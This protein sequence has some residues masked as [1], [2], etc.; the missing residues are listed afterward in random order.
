[1]Y[2]SFAFYQK[3][4]CSF[5]VHFLLLNEKD[6]CS[7]YVYFPQPLFPG[8]Y[9]LPKMAYAHT[10]LPCHTQICLALVLNL[11]H[12]AAPNGPAYFHIQVAQLS[13]AD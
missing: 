7:L 4:L 5:Y 1:M 6:V 3:D 10:V 11:N 2:I 9:F 8:H 12:I 13:S